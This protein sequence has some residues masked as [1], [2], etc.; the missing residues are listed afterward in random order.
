MNENLAQLLQ[1]LIMVFT[2]AI[3]GRSLMSWFPNSQNSSLGRF[4]YVV[5]EPILSPLRRI[6][7]RF[8][9]FDLTPTVAII[10]LI[11]LSYVVAASV[12]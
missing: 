2:F 3:V 11:V 5:T 10:L 12:E 7:P 1:A 8:G 9:M 6:I 4:L